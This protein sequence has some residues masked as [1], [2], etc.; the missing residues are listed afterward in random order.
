MN[1]SIVLPNV[2][3]FVGLVLIQVLILS[4][5]SLTSDG[6]INVLLYPLF[7]LLLPIETPTPVAVLLGFTIG[8]T[9][10]I[11]FGTLGVNASAG[12]LSGYARAV[13]LHR[14]APKGGYTGKEV[15]PAPVY[16]GW[17]WFIGLAAAFYAIHIFWYFAM[18]YFTPLY[19]WSKV[20]PHTLA[21]WPLSMAVVVVLVRL[22]HPKV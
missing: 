17:R 6:Y 12:A 18:A 21:A 10:D 3:R 14:F 8:L 7:I 4:E 2:W 16:F 5:V 11:F 19:I 15:I 20:L 9:V 22:F 13:L 1:S